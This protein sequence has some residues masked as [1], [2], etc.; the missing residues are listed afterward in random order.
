MSA[1]HKKLPNCSKC[2]FKYFLYNIYVLRLYLNFHI[3]CTCIYIVNVVIY[4]NCT[5]TYL[6][7]KFEV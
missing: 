3:C 2:D 5:C 1:I 6:Y 7:P 4:L